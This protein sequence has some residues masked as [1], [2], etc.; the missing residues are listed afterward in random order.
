MRYINSMRFIAIILICLTC[1]FISCGK[2]QKNK[3]N[4]ADSTVQSNG[5][6]KKSPASIPASKISTD[7]PMFMNDPS[8]RGISQD[9][10][11]RPPLFP[12]WKFKTGG[13]VKSSP[14]IVGDTLYVGSDDHRLY[15]LNADT[16]G[17]KWDFE[18]GGKITSSP[19]VYRGVVYFSSRD[20]KV[21]AL[22]AKTGKLKWATDVDGWVNS[23]V[24]AH[25]DKIY[26]GCYENKI[27]I[28]NA[29]TGK[30]REAR[31]SKTKSRFG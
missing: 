12:V 21:Y 17:L 11:L 19:T 23:P 1:L 29:E 15:A 28:I 9:K 22:D 2:D 6:S 7:W 14:V 31:K 25:S 26:V 18:T 10:S 5:V 20:L 13:P 3:T 30:K 27:Y 24:V 16:W 4:L 8:Y